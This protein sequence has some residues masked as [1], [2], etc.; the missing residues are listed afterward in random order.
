MS[1][2]SSV[3]AARSSRWL[4][5]KALSVASDESSLNA[6]SIASCDSSPKG[7]ESPASGAAAVG[8]AVLENATD[9]RVNCGI[10]PAESDG[11]QAPCR[12]GSVTGGVLSL[13]G[14]KGELI[15]APVGSGATGSDV[16]LVTEISN[17]W[18]L[19]CTPSTLAGI[20]KSAS[21]AAIEILSIVDA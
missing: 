20:S 19:P 21:M 13:A 8:K 4:E 17:A 6:A 5:L 14:S 7:N 15:C 16:S 11:I 2:A 1:A 12:F 3:A 9:G 18:N 10:A